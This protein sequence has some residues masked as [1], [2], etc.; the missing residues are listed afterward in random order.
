[1]KA[2]GDQPKAAY[3]AEN[4]NSELEQ[5]LQ[6]TET[7]QSV[8]V[9]T[10]NRSIAE[11]YHEMTRAWKQKKYRTDKEIDLIKFIRNAYDHKQE[12]S[13]QS[14]QY[15][16]DNIFTRKFPSLVLDVFGVVQQLKLDENCSF[17]LEHMKVD[18]DSGEHR[19]NFVTLIAFAIMTKLEDST[20]TYFDLSL[21]MMGLT[22]A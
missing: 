15:L 10:W 19:Y 1:M 13:L 14:Q 11:I 21:K 20:K 5:R 9:V 6:I 16:D 3:P 12:R 17:K 2:V 4:P 8:R 22:N 18:E 7:G